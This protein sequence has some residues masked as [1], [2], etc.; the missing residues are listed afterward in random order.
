M[1]LPKDCIAKETFHMYK[2]ITR[3]HHH[4]IVDYDLS[5]SY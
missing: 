3:S 4:L 1:V 5:D 2:G